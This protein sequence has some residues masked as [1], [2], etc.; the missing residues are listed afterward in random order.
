MLRLLQGWEVTPLRPHFRIMPYPDATLMPSL[1]ADTALSFPISTHQV[2]MS[3]C[4]VF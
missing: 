3:L 2:A 1:R 4:P